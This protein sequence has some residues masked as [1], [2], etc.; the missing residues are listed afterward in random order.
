MD[1]LSFVLMFTYFSELLL[2]L[3]IILI[4]LIKSLYIEYYQ[5]SDSIFCSL[6]MQIVT[7]GRKLW[8]GYLSR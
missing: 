8:R 1:T 5:L 4:T 7:F 3:S 6:H 2:S